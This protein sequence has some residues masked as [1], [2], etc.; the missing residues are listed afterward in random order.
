MSYPKLR[1]EPEKI[2]RRAE[3]SLENTTGFTVENQ[4]NS[5]IW[6]GF[7]DAATGRAIDVAPG[8]DRLFQG[9]PGAVF[10]GDLIIE[11]DETTVPAG[12]APRNLALIIKQ[13]IIGC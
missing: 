10:S 13:L 5:S 9:T 4:G 12:V 8:T 3:I 11:F 1:I 6:I 2:A 7:K